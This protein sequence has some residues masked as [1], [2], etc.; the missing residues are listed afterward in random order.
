[1]RRL[2]KKI[3]SVVLAVAMIGSMGSVAVKAD[4]TDDLMAGVDAFSDEAVESQKTVDAISDV[5][6]HLDDPKS[7]ISWG[8]GQLF[9]EMFKN[10]PMPGQKSEAEQISELLS[11]MDA[12]LGQLDVIANEIAGTTMV[13]E[14][15]QYKLLDRGD[16]ATKEYI[17]LFNDIDNDN[18]N[19]SSE[20]KEAERMKIL[21]YTM[22]GENEGSTIQDNTNGAYD[23]KYDAFASFA[24]TKFL[25]VDNEEL[26]MIEMYDRL[27]RINVKWYNNYYKAKIGFQNYFIGKYMS[28]AMLEKMSLLARAQQYEKE[29]PNKTARMLRA[30]MADIDEDVKA[31]QKVYGDNKAFEPDTAKRY[32]MYPGNE[33][34]LWANAKEQIIPTEPNRNRGVNDMATW[35]KYKGGEVPLKGVSAKKVYDFYP[36]L[37]FWR[38]FISYE[39]YCLCPTS[40]WLKRL[41]QNY[42]SK[43]S[44][45]DIFFDKNNGN[46]T[47]PS[48][49]DSKWLFVVD[50][51]NSLPMKYVK[52]TTVADN[53]TTP[54]VTSDGVQNYYAIYNYHLY[55]NEPRTDHRYIGLGVCPT[56][57]EEIEKKPVTAQSDAESVDY[58]VNKSELPPYSVLTMIGTDGSTIMDMKAH[59]LD[60]IT[61]TNQEFLANLY[62]NRLGKKANVVDTY[63]VYYRNGLRSCEPVTKK[64]LVWNNLAYK[65]QG[66]IYAAC[67]NQTDGAYYLLGYVNADGMAVFDGFIVNEATN[68]TIFTLQ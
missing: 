46:F 36:N 33:K 59:K 45:Y 29:H 11:K 41:Y 21:L 62:A 9:K 1:M 65:T 68:V 37:E 16:Y 26:Y 12:A 44:L 64:V 24:G 10:N 19:L 28:V 14:I 61:V 60:S 3:I 42:G 38:G 34:T 53:M 4:T 22:T 2:M 52:N 57:T 50:P 23:Q 63:G 43:V 48:G 40:D 7:L 47:A 8:A 58:D 15:N 27:L 17:K 32:Y 54:A 30:K 5:I 13:T 18:E 35:F 51:D 56:N 31:I 67:Y 39:Q 6:E 66:L 49:A 25:T 55:S 20:Q